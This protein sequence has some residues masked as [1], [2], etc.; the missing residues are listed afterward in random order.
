M[1][2]AVIDAIREKEQL[3]DS[4]TDNEIAKEYKGTYTAARAAIS[5][6][7][8]PLDQVINDSMAKIFPFMR[9]KK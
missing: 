9:K 1:E 7:H 3:P 6:D 2:K 5:L 8:K 4:M